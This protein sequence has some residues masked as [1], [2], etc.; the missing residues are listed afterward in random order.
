[1]VASRAHS[2]FSGEANVAQWLHTHTLATEGTK[3]SAAD[4]LLPRQG[5]PATPNN[6][7]S[8]LSAGQH[9]WR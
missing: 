8:M 7:W 5:P 4:S 6:S 1:M 2:S 3:A 9:A